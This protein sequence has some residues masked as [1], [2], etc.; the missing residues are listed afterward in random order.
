VL[1]LTNGELVTGFVIS[2]NG[3]Q[4]W[5]RDSQGQ[6]HKIARDDIEERGRQPIS[7]MPSGLVGNLE[8]EDLANLIAYLRSL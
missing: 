3:R 4:I 1:L 7:A 2:E 5:L 8:P 6:T